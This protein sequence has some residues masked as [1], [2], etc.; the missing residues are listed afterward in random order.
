M[1]IDLLFCNADVNKLMFVS[2]EELLDTLE[3]I[4]LL[5]FRKYLYLHVRR[6]SPKSYCFLG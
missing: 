1:V 2:G 6:I 4:K 5:L 3:I